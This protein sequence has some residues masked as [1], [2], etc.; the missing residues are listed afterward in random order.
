MLDVRVEEGVVHLT[1]RVE[2][3]SLIPIVV[4]MVGRVDG[5]VDVVHTLGYA[6]DDSQSGRFTRI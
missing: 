5:V 3:K 4:R 1:G 6:H 2:T